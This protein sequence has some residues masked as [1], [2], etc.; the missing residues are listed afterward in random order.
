MPMQSIFR[1][2]PAAL[3]GFADADQGREA[4]VAAC[5]KRA[6]GDRLAEHTVVLRFEGTR[7]YVAVANETWR[8]NIADLS[9]QMIFRLNS[10]L[11]TP[12]V[13]YIEFI[14]DENA[15]KASRKKDSA[16][17]K[18]RRR[19]ENAA[20]DE[21]TDSLKSS[22]EGIEDENLRKI[23][24]RAAASSLGRRNLRPKK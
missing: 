19:I 7:L 5:W 20:A 18:W 11:G 1:S 13:R 14:V 23:F 8:R 2:M 9:A 10:M 22:A 24:L 21:M 3:N 16:G 6:A 12:V 15:V 4:V 17:T